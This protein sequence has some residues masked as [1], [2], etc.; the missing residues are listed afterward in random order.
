[1]KLKLTIRLLFF[2]TCNSYLQAQTTALLENDTLVLQNKKVR[3][4]Y[5][6]NGGALTAIE[7]ADKNTGHSFHFY[8]AE[9]GVQITDDLEKPVAANLK[10]EKHLLS[11]LMPAHLSA[12]V[13]TNFGK[14]QLKRV[15]KIYPDSPAIGVEYYFKGKIPESNLIDELD[16]D[17]DGVERQIERRSRAVKRMEVIGLQGNHWRLKAVEFDDAT[18]KNNNLV[19]ERTVFIYRNPLKLRGNVFLS[20]ELISGNQ[21]FI[22]KESPL[23]EKQLYYPGYDV[24]VQTGK[25][26][27]TGLGV[28][29]ED[30]NKEVWTRGYG[31]A[32]GAGGDTDFTAL[33]GLRDY[34]KAKVAL[35]DE[36]SE[37]IMANT[38]GIAAET[39]A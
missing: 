14:W 31:Y 32:I 4:S 2:L 16:S 6:W 11:P 12:T 29:P 24:R 38:W 13:I 21:F 36:S 8:S 1:M 39:N 3:L 17:P 19:L 33:K 26:E 22:V 25:L 28:Q 10:V 30:V 23:D 18:D 27:I 9:P 20:K 5:L 15:F 37:M 35:K 7:L 34:L